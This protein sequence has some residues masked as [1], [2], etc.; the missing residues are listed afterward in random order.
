MKRYCNSNKRGVMHG[1]LIRMAKTLEV[2]SLGPTPAEEVQKLPRARQ[3]AMAGW[4][5]IE[6][7][8]EP[9]CQIY[10]VPFVRP[11]PLYQCEKAFWALPG[12]DG[13]AGVVATPLPPVHIPD[14]T[15]PIVTYSGRAAKRVQAPPAQKSK[16]PKKKKDASKPRRASQ[17][18]DTDMEP[19]A[20]LS[21]SSSSTD[22][23][24]DG[25]LSQPAIPRAWNCRREDAKVGTFA[26]LEVIYGEDETRGISLVQV[27]DVCCPC[28]LFLPPPL[29]RISAAMSCFLFEAKKQ[30]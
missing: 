3:N 17:Q 27:M 29:P 10:H 11:R 9:T 18:S 16:A 8:G 13:A 15:I 12:D 23:K 21:G 19:E 2:P 26:V 30:K 6:T 14:V 24:E 1:N 22:E 7:I 28:C 20:E 5:V 25:T 4:G